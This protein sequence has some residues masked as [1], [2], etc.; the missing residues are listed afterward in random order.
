MT[1]IGAETQY[2]EC[3]DAPNEL[4]TATGAVGSVDYLFSWRLTEI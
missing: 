4:F 3:P 1:K 2:L